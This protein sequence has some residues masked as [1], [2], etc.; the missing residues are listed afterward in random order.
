MKKVRFVHFEIAKYGGIVEEIEQRLQAF[1]DLG[2]DADIIRLTYKKSESE[3]YYKGKVKELESGEYFKE[4]K[5]DSQRAGM[6]KAISSGYW[7][8]PYYGW[9]LPPYTNLIPVFHDNALEF[10]NKAMEGVDLVFWSFMPT[11]T[12]SAEGFSEWW[13][14]FDLP[15]STQQV[16]IV[17]DGYFD[18]RS[19]WV[20]A[21][22]DKITFLECV[23]LAGF[24]SCNNIAIPRRNSII[25]RR[26]PNQMYE[27]LK[28]DREVDVFSAHIF[29]SMK[30]MDDIIRAIPHFSKRVKGH[31]TII[32]GADIE[33][34]Y[35][36]SETKTKPCYIADK[37]RDP[38]LFD[39]LEGK[40]IWDNALQY[41]MDY[42]GLLAEKTMIEFYQNSKFYIDASWSKHYAQY[43]STHINST[44][45]DAAINGCYPVLR[46]YRGLTKNVMYKDDF[47]FD[48]I[49]AVIIPWDATP[50]QFADML[51]DA[52]YNIDDE[53]YY[54][55]TQHNFEMF[56]KRADSLQIA[57]QILKTLDGE[58][59]ELHLGEDSDNVILQ[60]Y[61]VME[62]F[63]K[64]K[65]PIEWKK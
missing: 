39:G 5:S 26:F 44:T 64:I 18:Q 9:V 7:K 55:D 19:A 60:T 40:R 48:N 33:Y 27:K 65:L 25:P 32:G 34:N 35:M 28:S 14:Y 38:D 36:T 47:F 43:E 4:L 46:D 13:K 11:K 56:Y 42:R 2:W 22:K 51:A 30:K 20:T 63:F 59:D 31:K 29:K 45:I 6:E 24:N 16:F 21:L 12:G 49:K 15:E 62:N 17:H 23:H 8:N 52:Y 10:W 58:Y 54:F 53:Q 61:D 37:N 57:L 1:K 3:K 41:G 50:K